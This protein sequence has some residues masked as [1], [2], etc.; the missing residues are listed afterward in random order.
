MH[1]YALY[2]DFEWLGGRRAAGRGLR[3][4]DGAELSVG[5][6]CRAGRQ[7]AVQW[8]ELNRQAALRVDSTEGESTCV[9]CPLAAEFACAPELSEVMDKGQFS[10]PYTLSM[11]LGVT[12]GDMEQDNWR[13]LSVALLSGLCQRFSLK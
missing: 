5:L 4:L 9:Y 11:K 2:F 1:C 8:L 7:G 3:S 6:S 13:I 10:L 12:T